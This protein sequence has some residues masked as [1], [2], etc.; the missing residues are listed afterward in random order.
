MSERNL[1]R[2]GKGFAGWHADGV[3]ARGDRTGVQ[4]YS[5]SQEQLEEL[6]GDA[7]EGCVVYDASHL[8]YV[9]DEKFTRLVVS[10]PMSCGKLKPGQVSVC[11]EGV[12]EMDPHKATCFDDVCPADW[13]L[14]AKAWEP[15][16]RFGEVR[17]GQV[18]WE[19]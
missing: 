17:N 2:I 14:I 13:K 9:E 11:L 1:M 19:S 18:I 4:T 16:I 3:N 8:E 12:K 10:G 15:R 6:V 7:V 5:T